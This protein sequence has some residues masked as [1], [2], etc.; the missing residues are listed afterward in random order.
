MDNGDDLSGHGMAR[1][2]RY[3]TNAYDGPARSLLVAISGWS[4]LHRWSPLLCPQEDAVPSCAVA[5]LRPLRQRLP[6]FGIFFL[7]DLT[8]HYVCCFLKCCFSYFPNSHNILIGNNQ[9]IA[10]LSPKMW[11]KY[12]KRIESK[13]AFMT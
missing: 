10:E 3:K 6:L 8:R 2:R 13:L 4:V 1:R 9:N 7:P 5:F 11:Y 12:G